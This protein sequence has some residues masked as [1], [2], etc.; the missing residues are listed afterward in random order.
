MNN[1]TDKQQSTSTTEQNQNKKKRDNRFTLGPLPLEIEDIHHIAIDA[2]EVQRWNTY[3][4]IYGQNMKTV[5]VYGRCKPCGSISTQKNR[6]VK[7]Y[8]VD[9]GSGM[10]IVH[11][12]HFNTEYSGE[13]IFF[14]HNFFLPATDAPSLRSFIKLD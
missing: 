6:N 8:E 11:F 13:L 9:D 2:N 4:K 1:G 12:A 10:V 14:V 5:M 3:Q 7:L